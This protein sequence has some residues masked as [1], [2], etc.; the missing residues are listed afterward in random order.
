[1]SNIPNRLTHRETRH[2]VLN[3]TATPPPQKPY[4]NIPYLPKYLNKY[5]LPSLLN[6]NEYEHLFGFGAQEFYSIRDEFVEPALI[7][8][9]KKPHLGTSDAML[10]LFLIKIKLKNIF[11]VKNIFG[12]KK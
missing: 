1:M 7:F 4:V 5:L 3:G 10:A 2:L 8:H 11:E 12:V 9:H 6:P